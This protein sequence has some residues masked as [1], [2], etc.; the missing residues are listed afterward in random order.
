MKKNKIPAGFILAAL[1]LISITAC[2]FIDY[3][4]SDTLIVSAKEAVKLMEKGYTLV[5][6]Q[7]A[8]SYEKGHI[9]TAVNI[10]RKAIMISDPV[11]NTLATPEIIEQAAGKAGLTENT[12]ILIYDDNKNMDA[13][14]LFWT[15]KIY[16]HKGDIKII[17]GGFLALL[18]EG[19]KETK[20]ASSVTPAAYTASA[21]D[22]SMIEKKGKIW[23]LIDD[24]DED[25]V[26]ID[27]R[28]FDEYAEGTIP[29]AIHIN[30]ERNMFVNDEKGTTFR[31]VSHN[32]ILYK[33]MGITPDKEIIMF[34]KSSVRA[35]NTY[36]ALY[37]AGYRNLKIYD[38]AWLEWEASNLPVFKP[39]VSGAA[40]T[41][42]EDNS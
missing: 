33:E 10:E 22:K 42:V 29:G 15:L 12:N 41:A 2:S 13:T 31:P 14:R 1:L 39:E 26:L 16:G 37:N 40:T 19:L 34:C 28:S 17:S 21:L 32:R 27:V 8:S 6:A 9:E 24:P 3:A 30:H 18:D 23:G 25:I 35:A 7:K 5:D 11:P 20:K 36:A 4:E 38:G